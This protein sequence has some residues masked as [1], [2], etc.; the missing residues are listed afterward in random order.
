M[1]Q[2]K[3]AITVLRISSFV[4]LFAVCNGIL[5]VNLLITFGLKRQL[6]MI[7][8]AGGVFS[9]ACVFPAAMLYQANGVAFV[10]LSTE[11]IITGLLLWTF[12]RHKIELKLW[13]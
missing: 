3:E 10:A 4:P 8:G 13:K 6:L 5:A 9:L 7:V 12:N 11:M 1:L 2:Y